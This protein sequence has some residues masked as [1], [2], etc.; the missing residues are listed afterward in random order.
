MFGMHDI[1]LLLSVHTGTTGDTGLEALNELLK[2]NRVV[3]YKEGVFR[4]FVESSWHF[5]PLT[6]KQAGPSQHVVPASPH[7]PTPGR[8]GLTWGRLSNLGVVYSR[9]VGLE[10]S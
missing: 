3:V 4:P 1:N 6:G 8:E 9:G 2:E 10:T 7:S 5:L